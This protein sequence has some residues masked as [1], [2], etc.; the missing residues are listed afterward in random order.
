MGGG[1]TQHPGGAPDRYHLTL[2]SAGRPAMHGWWADRAVADRKLREWIGE[3]GSMPDARVT[4]ADEETGSV[5]TDW[6]D[7]T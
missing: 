2:S 4:L 6:P 5:L 3:Y 1:A 7:E